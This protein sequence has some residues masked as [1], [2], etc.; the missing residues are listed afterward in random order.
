MPS[1]PVLFPPRPVLNG[2]PPTKC[3]ISW[4]IV[5]ANTSVV[6]LE[7]VRY[8]LLTSTVQSSS[9]LSSTWALTASLSQSILHEILWVPAGFAAA[10]WS[11]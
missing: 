8:P 5:S 10:A 9:G 1:A 6:M 4:H 2:N 11:W 7:T 3:P